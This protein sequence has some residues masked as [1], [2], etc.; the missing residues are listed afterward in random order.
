[1]N[2]IYCGGVAVL[3]SLGMA[4]GD[5]GAAGA[6]VPE[7]AG[8]AL[9][10]VSVTGLQSDDGAVRVAVFDRPEA[11]TDAPLVAG[12]LAPTGL[13]AEWSVRVPFG[14]YAVA[15]VHDE[16]GN[17]ELNTNFLGMPRERYGFSNDVRGT[18]GPPSFGDASLAVDQP[19]VRIT[20]PVR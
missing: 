18:F 10:T 14:V 1:M 4:A 6:Q 19:S 20:V 3:I 8:E 7:A 13:S 17:G 12:V 2:N 11:F 16:D 9:L 15:V 5:T